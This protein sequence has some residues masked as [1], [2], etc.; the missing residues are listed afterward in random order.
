MMKR[1][2]ILILLFT[3]SLLNAQ[4]LDQNMMNLMDEVDRNKLLRGENTI[5]DYEGSPYLSGEFL[6]GSIELNDERTFKDIPLRYNIFNDN[7]EVLYEGKE[8]GLE[9]SARF[10]Q[11]KIDGRVFMYKAYHLVKNKAINGY[12]EVL[13]E[14]EYTLFCKHNV[15]FVKAKAAAAYKE[16]VPATFK[17]L[18]PDYLMQDDTGNI[19]RI[20]SSKDIIEAF[21]EA[22]ALLKEYSPKGKIK[23]RREEDFVKLIDFMN[24]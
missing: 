15:T 24:K 10:R 9:R 22:E 12:L 14:G 5:T 20:N 6:N 8:Y 13:A 19:V 2:F 17:R 18:V 1:I 23:L 4:I 16:A 3:G 11:F 21:P 7:F